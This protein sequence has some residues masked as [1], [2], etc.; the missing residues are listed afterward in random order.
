MGF[1]EDATAW[2]DRHHTVRKFVKGF[3]VFG[4]G[5]VVAE[6]PAIMAALPQWAIIP[7]GALILA[8][9]NYIKHNTTLPIVG[10]KR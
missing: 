9:D 8:L 5:F 7:V 2:F 1:V 3:I 4:I 10:A 6:Q